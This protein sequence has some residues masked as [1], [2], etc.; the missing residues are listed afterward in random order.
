MSWR[1]SVVLL[2]AFSA[3]LSP[4]ALA[5]PLDD[6]SAAMK[7]M[8]NARYRAEMTITDE[9]GSVIKSVVEHDGPDRSHM[10]MDTHEM[11]MLPDARWMRAGNGKWMKSPSDPNRPNMKNSE[12]SMRDKMLRNAKE[13]RDE[14]MTTFNGQAVRAYHADF[15]M[16]MGGL[17]VISHGRFYLNAAGQLVGSESDGEALGKK[18]HTVQKITYDNSIRVQAPAEQ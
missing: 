9:K 4:L 15:D 12:A 18:S 13:V 7:K 8:E 10:K 3:A 5:A 2:V 16:D 11:I 6:V 14:G 1:Q 17:H